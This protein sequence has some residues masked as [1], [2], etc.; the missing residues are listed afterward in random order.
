MIFGNLI[1]GHL[2]ILMFQN[3]PAKKVAGFRAVLK[4][5]LRLHTVRTGIPE[6][7][8]T[9]LS[10]SSFHEYHSDIP[11]HPPDIPQTPSRQLQGTQDIN[12][13]QQTTSDTSRHPRILTGAV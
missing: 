1:Y 10:A 5:M 6:T 9:R 2:Y 4:K 12:R 13:R 7:P 11:R 8:Q 3:G